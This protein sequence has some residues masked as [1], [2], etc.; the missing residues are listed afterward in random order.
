MKRPTLRTYRRTLQII[1]ALAFVLIPYLNTRGVN[2]FYGNFLSFY[3]AG[4]PLADPLA[5]LQVTLKSWPIPSKLLIGA[6][7]AL[8]LA[9]TLGTVFCSWVCPFGLLSE[10]V[11]GMSKRI[12][13]KNYRAIRGKISGFPVKGYL[14]ILS[15]LGFLLLATTPFL[16]QFSLPAWYSRIFQLIVVQKYLSLAIGAILVILL[17]EF[18]TQNRLWCRYLCVQAVL[19]VLFQLLNPYRLRV[20]Y[21]AKKC[22]CKADPEPCVGSCSLSLNPKALVRSLETECT[23]CGDCVV[24]CKRVGNALGFQLES[25]EKSTLK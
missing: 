4:I 14:L 21:S 3:A 24:A 8:L 19:L 20:C 16:N 25:C 17:L 23:N 11:H 2:L 7:I 18:I 9:F 1:V 12:L 13:P 10:L 15:L 5:V 6:G 22:A